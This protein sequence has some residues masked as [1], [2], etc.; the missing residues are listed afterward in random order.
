VISIVSRRPETPAPELASG[1]RSR[2]T[3]PVTRTF[4]PLN[5]RQLEVLRWIGDGCP[6]GVIEG[7]SYKTTAVA[8][9]NR[10]LVTV[11]KKGGVWRA[12]LADAGAYY[13][14]HDT[15][16]GAPL[17][18][19][20]PLPVRPDPL[21]PPPAGRVQAQVRPRTAPRVARPKT[22]SPTEQLI[23]ELETNGEVRISGSEQA[24]YE[25][26]VAAARRYGKVPEGKQ[27]VTEGGR[28]SREYVIRLREAPAWLDAPLNPIPVP[29]SLRQPHPVVIA[30]QAGKQLKGIDR[31]ATHRALLL[32]QALAVEAQE[33]GYTVK[34]TKVT[35]D[36]YGY[37][38]RESEDH[39]SIATG[40]HS[41]GVQLRQ[42][43]DRARHEATPAEQAK[44][45]RDRWYRIPKFDVT[46][47]D[48]LSIQLSGRF[49]HR[50]SKWADGRIGSLEDWLPQILQE[51]ELR[52][53][54][55]E[56]ARLAAIAA[57]EERR[58]Q[59]EHAMENAKADY[60]E[61]Y[62]TDILLRQLDGW[63]RARQVRDYLDVMQE[64]IDS[65]TDPDDAVAAKEWHRWAEEWV[66]SADPLAQPLAMP[67]V[68]EPK[69]D[70]LKPFLKGWNPYGP[71][72]SGW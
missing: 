3:E 13:L 65:I 10:R 7:Y 29:A 63:L 12:A 35:T 33:R 43:M 20:R 52:T 4:S 48:R 54:A 6:N 16:P 68:P 56:H 17:T 57:A 69:P 40:H 64:T 27:L 72:R 25:A 26:R 38:R 19:R 60:A 23:K 24:K 44:A 55:A 66:A 51:V 1:T 42:I 8:L 15:Y 67:A 50:Q 30:L 49:E 45:A 58:R 41:V 46:P 62:R 37:E 39:F 18:A 70:D 53:E 2:Y 28:W 31:S 59:W 22:P 34:E 71:E 5:D 32:I 47:S 21:V 11:S 36:P 14:E 9:G 61:A